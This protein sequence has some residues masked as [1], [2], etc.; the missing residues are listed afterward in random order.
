MLGLFLLL[1]FSL[2]LAPLVPAQL[3]AVSTG[4]TDG[5]DYPVGKPNGDGF[6][7]SRGFSLHGHLGEDWVRQEG[8]GVAFRN[9]VSS[10]GTGVVTLARDFL[11]AWGNVVVIRHAFLEDGQ[12][13][14]VDSLYGHLD[15]ILVSE[16]Q[17]VSRGQQIGTIGTAHG[18]YPPHL[19]F[20]IHPNLTIGVVHTGFARDFSNY[21]DPTRFLEAHRTLK[22]SSQKVTVFLGGYTMPSFAGIPARPAAAGERSDGLVEAGAKR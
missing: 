4:L 20:E 19:H 9:P 18:L 21:E 17:R 3:T 15:R 12:T 16:G 11:R 1:G 8:S 2:A 22:P 10:V 5:F 6:Y 7:K 14:Y 13:K